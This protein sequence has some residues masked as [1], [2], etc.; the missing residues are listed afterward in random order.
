MKSFELLKRF[1]ISKQ[2]LEAKCCPC[3]FLN[4]DSRPASL[5]VWFVFLYFDHFATTLELHFL[6]PTAKQNKRVCF[7][8]YSGNFLTAYGTF[9]LAQNSAIPLTYVS[10]WKNKAGGTKAEPKAEPEKFQWEF[11]WH[12]YTPTGHS[13]PLWNHSVSFLAELGENAILFR[14]LF[15]TCSIKESMYFS[16][17]SMSRN[18]RHYIWHL[19]RLFQT[20]LHIS[21]LVAH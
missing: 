17:F 7:W 15:V 2:R 5:P 16:F 14:L 20:F 10:S 1:P 12:Q 18:Q 19:L 13:N 21:V 8:V 4:L 11:L 6:S 3:F 9:P